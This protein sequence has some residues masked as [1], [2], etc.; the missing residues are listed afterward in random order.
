MQPGDHLVV[1]KWGYDHHGLYAGDSKVI[2]YVGPLSSEAPLTGRVVVSALETSAG[3]G[4]CYLRT[5]SHRYYSPAQSLERA[6]RRL[7]ERAYHLQ[8][9]NCEHFVTWCIQGE[10]R[11]EQV[12]QAWSTAMLSIALTQEPPPPELTTV[13]TTLSTLTSWVRTLSTLLPPWPFR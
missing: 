6:Y 1:M 5:Y 7:G 10:H 4:P 13:P 2:H 11:S 12:E 3:D 8:F 9:N